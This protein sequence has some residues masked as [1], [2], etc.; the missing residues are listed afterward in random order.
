MPISM[1]GHINN[2]L[3]S[4]PVEYVERVQGY[5]DTGRPTTT[6]VQRASYPANIQPLQPDEIDF[7]NR[8]NVRYIDAR[9][10]YINSGNLDILTTQGKFIFL[11]REWTVYNID[12][13]VW[14]SYVKVIVY[15]TDE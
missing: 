1:S 10:I 9:K 12:K 3:L 2:V 15:A 5:D 4:I 7:L 11:N 6:D 14:N 8:G 13:R